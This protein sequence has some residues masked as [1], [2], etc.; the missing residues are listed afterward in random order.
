MNSIYKIKKKYWLNNIKGNIFCYFKQNILFSLMLKT[1]AFCGYIM[2]HK[3]KK[4]GLL[5]KE[6]KIMYK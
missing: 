4:K 3:S 6:K 1:P 2:T 5:I